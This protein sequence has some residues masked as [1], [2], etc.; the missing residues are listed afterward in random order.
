MRGGLREAMTR[1][2][3][4]SL[5]CWIRRKNG[6]SALEGRVFAYRLMTG[7]YIFVF[8][9]VILSCQCTQLNPRWFIG[10]GVW[11]DTSPDEPRYSA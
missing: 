4:G 6:R 10:T 7:L 5:W 1:S 9:G 2:F 3:E 8:T 11:H